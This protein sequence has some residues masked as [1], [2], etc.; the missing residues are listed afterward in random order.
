VKKLSVLTL[1]NM[2]PNKLGALEEYALALSRE[3]IAQG[4]RA[5]VAFPDDPS[6]WLVERFH[7]E[8][9]PVLKLNHNDGSLKF[10]SRVRNAI[11]EYDF[12]ILHA[13]F[14]PFYDWQLV[15]GTLGTGCRLIYS[16]QVS[17]TG[18]PRGGLH[19]IPRLIKHRLLLTQIHA[20]IADAQYVRHCQIKD[21]F[22]KPGKI[23]VVYNGVNLA[24]FGGIDDEAKARFR[25]Q[26]GLDP[27]TR[28][29]LTI[30]QCIWEKG[31]NY[32]IDAAKEVVCKCPDT[33]FFVVGDGPQRSVFEQQVAGLGLQDHFVFTGTRVDTELFLAVS[34]IFVLLSVWE[35]A[36]AFSLLEAMA[37]RCPVVATRIGAIPESILDGETGLLVPPRDAGATATALLKLLE[38]EEL[39]KRMGQMGRERVENHFSLKQWVD[40]TIDLYLGAVEDKS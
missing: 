36:F 23:P 27:S 5:G 28:V 33:R 40:K 35:E 26:L 13:T 12:N 10:V 9:I 7:S 19:A 1:I 11:K 37:S 24:R 22:T 21:L 29:V 3:L 32:L 4:H 18:H 6:D 30:A 39:R 38:E 2:K 31:I 15:A 16:D 8:K 20:I 34:D 17:R 25:E 14:Y